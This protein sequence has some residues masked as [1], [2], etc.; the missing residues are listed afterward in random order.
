MSRL[1]T[2]AA[3]LL[4][5][6]SP[7]ARLLIGLVLLYRLAVSPMLAPRCRFEPSC[8]AYGLDA[9]RRFGAVRGTVLIG[10]RLA[11]CQPFC[12]GGFDPVPQRGRWGLPTWSRTRRIAP[13]QSPP[14]PPG[15]TPLEHE[16]RKGAVRC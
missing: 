2:L 16:G 8:S 14:R 5:R 1:G 10:W 9:L 4:W 3:R 11:R 6:P 7:L 15:A 13:A 12:R